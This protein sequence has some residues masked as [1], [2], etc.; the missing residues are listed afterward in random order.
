MQAADNI[1]SAGPDGSYGP[2]EYQNSEVLGLNP[3]R[4]GYVSSKLCMYSALNRSKAW[5]LQ[6]YLWYCAL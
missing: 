3:G 1:I 6:C 5:G 4:V 2:V